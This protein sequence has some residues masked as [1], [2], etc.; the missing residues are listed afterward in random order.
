MKPRYL[1]VAAML[2]ILTACGVKTPVR[3]PIG[4]VP[5]K[6]SGFEARPRENTIVLFW[7]APKPAPE[8]KNTPAATFNIQRRSKPHEKESWGD[9]ED[10]ASI[11]APS[12]GGNVEWIDKKIESG[13]DYQY[14][15]AQIDAQGNR[16]QYSKIATTGW[17]TPPGAPI[18][19]IA[20]PGDRTVTLRWEPPPNEQKI[21][22]YYIYRA[23][24][25]KDF[26]LVLRLAVP[27]T[28]FVDVGL[29]N[30]VAYRYEVRAARAAGGALMVEGPASEIAP[31]IPTDRIPPQVPIGVG[32]F[33][34]PEGVKVIWWPNNEEDLTGY[35]VYRVS[36]RETVKLT[37][38]PIKQS[39]YLDVS[40]V[41]GHSYSYYVTS[42]DNSNN[43]SP[44]SE[45]AQVF[46]K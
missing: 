31:V 25:N 39:E 40:T 32:A 15:V 34:S 21:D 11:N 10:Y 13:M 16:G 46:I 43:E 1:I 17:E 7:K 36:G 12:E 24:G 27:R 22:G 9:F 30:G 2:S 33:I 41:K 35:N 26:Q 28:D 4:G 37:V 6:V 20:E 44:R 42:V 14:R 45:P 3:P 29:K 38:A 19:L 5:A 8:S 18:K 23:E